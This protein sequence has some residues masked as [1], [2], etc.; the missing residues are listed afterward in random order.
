[1]NETMESEWKALATDAQL[2]LRAIR[3]YAADVFGEHEAAMRWLR[4][5]HLSVR[6]A[7]CTIEEASQSPDGFF[8][9]MAELARISRFSQRENGKRQ[10]MAPQPGRAERPQAA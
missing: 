4:R 6:R 9:A 5:S 2:R 7:T 1:M 10:Q 3:E 8:E